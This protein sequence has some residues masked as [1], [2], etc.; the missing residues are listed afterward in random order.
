[1]TRADAGQPLPTCSFCGRDQRAARRLVA[2]PGELCICDECVGLCN[3]I[4]EEELADATELTWDS[5]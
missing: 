3:E 5:L 4:I 1:M 2:G